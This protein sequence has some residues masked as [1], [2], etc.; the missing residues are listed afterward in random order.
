M[1]HQPFDAGF[2]TDYIEISRKGN[3][4]MVVR[5]N[6]LKL[7]I[8]SGAHQSNQWIQYLGARRAHERVLQYL[9]GYSNQAVIQPPD[10]IAYHARHRRHVHSFPIPV[11]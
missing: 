1:V 4:L 11:S 3:G 9:I 2:S 7:H 6:V 5:L 8:Q 10:Q